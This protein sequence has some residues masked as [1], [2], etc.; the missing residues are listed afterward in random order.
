MQGLGRREA[1]QAF[2]R[3]VC[4][5]AARL[6]VRTEV[7]SVLK[8]IRLA[9]ELTVLGLILATVAESVISEEST[10]Q[11]N[12]EQGLFCHRKGRKQ[13]P[14]E[15]RISQLQAL[16]RGPVTQPFL[17]LGLPCVAQPHLELWTRDLP[18]VKST[19]DIPEA[20]GFGVPRNAEIIGPQHKQSGR[21]RL[22]RGRLSR[23]RQKRTYHL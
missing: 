8:G 15:G 23:L 19:K 5:C 3:H 14:C 9:T 6:K 20:T 7:N 22:A 12:A 21:A 2:L 18:Q 13:T 16:K 1:A 10:I 4:L 11:R 17:N